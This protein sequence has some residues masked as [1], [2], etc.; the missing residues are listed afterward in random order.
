MCPGENALLPGFS[1][2]GDGNEAAT[3]DATTT[4]SAVKG[5]CMRCVQWPP[6]PRCDHIC[7]PVRIAPASVLQ[8]SRNRLLSQRCRCS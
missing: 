4:G 7:G 8:T 3:Q 5:T 2:S 6:L 1:S